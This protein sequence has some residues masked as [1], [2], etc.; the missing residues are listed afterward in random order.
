[1]D[2]GHRNVGLR[3]IAAVPAQARSVADRQ[4]QYVLISWWSRCKAAP[5]I[6]TRGRSNWRLE[7]EAWPYCQPRPP[8]SDVLCSELGLGG[9]G[10]G[11][12]IP[13]DPCT[14]VS[15]AGALHQPRHNFAL[16]GD[17]APCF[18]GCA[19]LSHVCPAVLTALSIHKQRRHRVKLKRD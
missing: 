5:F 12:L 1:M 4:S 15:L 13:L 17:P 2:V 6:S 11:T 9:H 18:C 10:P 3:K 16:G 7:R 19:L 8:T 14:T